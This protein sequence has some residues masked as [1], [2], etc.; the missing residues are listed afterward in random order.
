MTKPVRVQFDLR[1][2]EAQALDRLR[3][4]LDLGTRKDTV[5]TA[6]A[7]LEW[8]Q[9]EAAAGRRVLG[10]GADQVS[11]LSIPGLTAAAEAAAP[12]KVE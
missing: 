9:R 2:G 8:V 4:A 1:A 10:V 12:E 3:G 11:F 7:V 6:L 5:R